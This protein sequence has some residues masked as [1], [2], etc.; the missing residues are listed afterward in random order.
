MGFNLHFTFSHEVAE[1]GMRYPYAGFFAAIVACVGIFRLTVVTL[2]YFAVLFNLFLLPGASL[3]KYGAGKGA[4]VVITGASDGIGKEYAYQLAARGFNVGLV[5]RTESKLLALKE[6]IESKYKVEARV[7]AMDVS[8][9]NSSNYQALAEFVEG[10][11]V[12]VLINN[13]GMSH[14]IPTPFL[15][16]SDQELR[17]IITINNIA[18]LKFTQI[19]VPRILKNI[20]K[21]GVAKRGLVLTMGSFAGLTPT[22]LLATYSG[23]KAFLQ[24]WNNAMARELEPQGVDCQLVLS[25]LVTSAMSKIRRTSAMIPN[26]K[27]F[28]K[29]AIHSIGRRVGAQERYATTTPYWSHALLHWLLENSIGVWSRLLISINYNMHVDIRKRALRKAEKKK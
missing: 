2:S 27:Q 16:T 20:E 29:S 1:I 3:K 9:D 23:S 7:L 11:N 12:T 5:S 19:V 8:T 10:L 4:W 25:Y 28:V 21:N 6:E 15:E 14:S 24:A 18:T 22:P 26:P 13:V 17:N